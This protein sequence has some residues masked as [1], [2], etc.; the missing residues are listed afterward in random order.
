MGDSIAYRAGTTLG[1]LSTSPSAGFST[2]VHHQEPDRIEVRFESYDHET[3]IE[4]RLVAGAV[5]REVDE[6]PKGS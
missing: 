4:V 6:N 2:E 5:P 1:L 3:R